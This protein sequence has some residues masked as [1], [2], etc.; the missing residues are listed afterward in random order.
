M[1]V[2]E[3]EGSRKE[4]RLDVCELPAAL[5]SGDLKPVII[6]E[7]LEMSCGIFDVTATVFSHVHVSDSSSGIQYCTVYIHSPFTSEAALPMCMGPFSPYFS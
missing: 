5:D 2:Y 6:S 4:M 1:K 7:L 3:A